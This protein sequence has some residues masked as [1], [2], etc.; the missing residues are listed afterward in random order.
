MKTRRRS[1]ES[2]LQALYQCDVLA[3]WSNRNIEN[4]FTHFQT[5]EIE[6]EDEAVKSNISYARLVINGIKENLDFLDRKITSAS[7]R[8]SVKRMPIIDR[9]ILRLAVYE[10]IFVEDIPT[11][12]SINE[13]IEIAK[14]YS[15]EDSYLF[16]N[17][18]LDKIAS[19]VQ[20]TNNSD[21]LKDRMTA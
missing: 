21:P 13:A 2:I 6:D 8:W 10:I 3:D 12:V 7:T 19:S 20:K 15:T 11:N 14:L 5:S 1:R 17:G 9:N 4:Y 16:I 18:I